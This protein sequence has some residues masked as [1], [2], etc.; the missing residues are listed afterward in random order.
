MAAT[1]PTVVKAL[2]AVLTGLT[3]L[4]LAILLL[5]GGD[6]EVALVE[7]NSEIEIPQTTSAV[8]QSQTATTLTTSETNSPEVE[9]PQETLVPAQPIVAGRET[10]LIGGGS[11]CTIFVSTT[12]DD[13][14]AGTSET[15][16]IRSP[17]AAVQRAQAGDVVCFN[18]GSY[19]YLGIVDKN[20][21]P[22]APIEFRSINGEAVFELANVDDVSEEASIEVRNSSHIVLDGLAASRALRGVAISASSQTEVLNCRIAGT[23]Q[24]AL[25][26]QSGSTDAR[27]AGCDISDTGNKE[28]LYTNGQAFS[29]FGELVYV[30][31]GS[32]PG[33]TTSNV[34]IE[35][36]ILHDNG[37]ATAEAVNVKS[38]TSNVTIRN[39]H[40]YN[41]DSWCEAAIRVNNSANLVV[42]N[43]II[44][45]IT[46]SGSN[47]FGH[48]CSDAIGIRFDSPTATIEN[49]LVFRA[50]KFGILADNGSGGVVRNNTM[51]D[52]GTD[53]VTRSAV[54]TENNVTSDGTDGQQVSAA[55]FVGPLTGQAD[56]GS[57]P[58]SGFDLLATNAGFSP[59]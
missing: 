58:G 3:I 55:D 10:S 32:S 17:G 53:Y 38:E 43:N 24:E 51:F 8:P 16:A 30:G 25:Y 27:V 54:Q 11:D 29:V 40:I 36:N 12:G 7:Q 33:D 59:S 57:G 46:A 50:G 52:N 41:I 5:T 20:G 28:G 15:T 44:H 42:A 39:N 49:N 48:Q 21:A 45:D 18:E 47:G 9:I 1:K 26:V 34:V 35:N 23:G 31:S 6:D 22:N 4:T 13:N 2:I 14:A 56:A 19:G 37:N